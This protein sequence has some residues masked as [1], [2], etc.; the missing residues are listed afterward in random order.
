MPSE[1]GS[2][3]APMRAPYGGRAPAHL[4]GRSLIDGP[5]APALIMFSL[6]LLGTN[7]LQ[8]LSM[9][10]NAIW[11][12]HVLGPAALTATVNAQILMML[13]MGAVMGVGMAGNIVLAQAFGAGDM[14]NVKRVVG[15][16][17]S[18]FIGAS[19]VLGVTGVL[20]TPAILDAMGTPPDARAQAVIYL[21]YTCLSMPV[22]F[23]FLFSQMMLRASG[24]S[25][26]PFTYSL[27][28]IVLGFIF[29]PLLMTG[30]MGT[31]RL[32]IAGAA[33]AGLIAQAIA[34]VLFFRRIYMSDSPMALRGSDLRFLNP[35]WDILRV[36]F[37]RGMPMGL[38]MFVLSGASI[39]ML[40]MV[41]FYGSNVAA[42]Y[43]AAT[44]LWSYVQM[45]A[46]ALAA[47]VSSMAAQ[48][49]GAGRWDRVNQIA[50]TAVMVGL[51][52]TGGVVLFLYALGDLPLLLFLPSGSEALRTAS[53][54]NHHVLW[55]WIP[56]AITFV[57][58]GIVR[59][60]GAIVP[61]TI[62]LCI[63]LWAIRV[64]FA[65]E[66]KPWLGQAS[67]WWSFPLG[68]IASALGA[69]GYYRWG[70]W[71]KKKLMM[72]TFG[73]PGAHGATAAAAAAHPEALTEA[74][75]AATLA[76]PMEA[77]SPEVLRSD[78]AALSDLK[79][80]IEAMMRRHNLLQESA[81]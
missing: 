52:I 42:G 33:I 32:G 25:R 20:T 36:L 26:T 34:L 24:D 62:I 66:L 11:V 21:R 69:F 79:R 22:V 31:P 46:M 39:V 60:N 67:I 4:G 47:S 45:P 12:S 63:A 70:G 7:A 2:S 58:F 13:L 30:W 29:T 75:D 38:Q 64:P 3:T 8:S 48:N 14:G 28:A 49:I 23:T 19:V 57:L 65:I 44:Q 5:I 81:E 61:P 74:P 18:F 15:T 54:I 76:Q 55:G 16:A 72:T 6:P 56:F 53:T 27:I 71:R 68:T 10:V 43:G 80:D 51:G 50:S 37:L 73:R 77:L 17:M 78:A 1:A 9:T 40:K 35:D 41:N 59:A